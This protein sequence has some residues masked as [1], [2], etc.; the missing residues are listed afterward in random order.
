MEIKTTGKLIPA[1]AVGLVAAAL[2]LLCF[3]MSWITISLF[4][5]QVS[6]SGYQLATGNGPGGVQLAGATSLLLVPLGMLAVIAG[7]VA[8]L[9]N[10]DL[11]AQ[12]NRY[13]PTTLI[14]AGGLSAAIIFYQYSNLESQFDGTMAGMLARNV[15]TYTFSA[16]LALFGSIVV[17]IAGAL[18]L[19]AKPAA[20][21]L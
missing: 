19:R 12:I 21:R 14:A 6:L 10:R 17:A 4:V 3:F 18:A 11:A 9:F 13:L 8:C 16:K 5:T 1:Q 7:I 15:V 2:V 20:D